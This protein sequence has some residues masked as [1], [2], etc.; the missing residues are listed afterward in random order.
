MQKTIKAVT[1]G[2]IHGIG[3]QL[4]INLWKF[5]KNK[6]GKFILISNYNLFEKY[7]KKNNIKLSYIK[8]NDVTDTNKIFNYHLPIFNIKANNNVTNSYNSIKIGYS[9]TKKNICK[10]LITLPINKEK[11]INKIDKSFIGQTELLEKLDN[12]QF[13]NMIFYSKKI[14]VTTLTTHIPLNK[15]NLYLKQKKIIFKKIFSINETLKRD[16]KILNPKIV[17]C[18]INPHAG[19]NGKIGK[20]E[21]EFINPIIKKLINKGVNIEGPLSADTIFNSTNRAKYDCFICIYHDQALIPFK[22]LTGFEGVN[23]TGSLNI[24]RTSP[25]HGTAY[26]LVNKKLANDKSLIN[27]F[28]LA[29]RIYLNRL[30]N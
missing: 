7:I 1:I 22:L 17:I 18:G 2:D 26:N 10:A 23:Y 5:K 21:E 6:I 20:E 27:S 25:N 11:I 4:L 14:L 12:K 28:I 13:S 19:E 15:I 30:R 29:D 8:I 16:F 3:I 24:I 9:L